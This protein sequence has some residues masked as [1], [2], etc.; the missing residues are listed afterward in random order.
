VQSTQ[1]FYDAESKREENTVYHLELDA[2][3]VGPVS[4]VTFPGEVFDISGMYIKEHSPFDTT[5]VLSCAN[6]HYG[7]LPVTYAH[8]LD[9]IAYEASASYAVRGTI[10][11]VSDQ[12]L[13]MLEEH[14]DAAE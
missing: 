11:R 5:F 3:S 9:P 13:G 6:G 1:T 14:H 4:F 8:D 2:I 12:L 10:E 7:Y